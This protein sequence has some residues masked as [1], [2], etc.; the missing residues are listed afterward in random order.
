MK[1]A[2][3]GWAQQT[4]LVAKVYGIPVRVDYRWFAVF[5]LSVWLMA[6]NLHNGAGVMRAVPWA[7]AWLLGIL[8]TCG[9]FLCI[10]GHELAHAIIARME[11]IET[12][13]IVLHPFGGL[14]RLA[15]LPETPKAEFRIALA[16]P[17]AS[18]MFAALLLGA[19]LIA[20]A[21]DYQ[22][23]AGCFFLLFFGNL[24]L[25]I[26]NLFP[27][28]PLDGGRVLR[29]Y[30]WARTGDMNEAT[31]KASRLGQFIA[32][33]IIAFGA[34][35][36]I[37][38]FFNRSGD[39][40][41]GLWSILIGFFLRGAAA[42]VN[43]EETAAATSSVAQ[44]MGAPLTLSPETLVSEFVDHTLEKY[45]YAVF[46]VGQAG[47]LHGM[48]LLEDVKKL[49]RERWRTVRLRE[50]MRPVAPEMFVQTSTKLAQARELMQKNGAQAVVVLDDKGLIVGFLRA[51][52]V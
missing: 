46:P 14:A 43:R 28:Y 7:T 36:L 42:G 15:R 9:F 4:L 13:E 12:E 48:L 41:T 18:F 5:L 45:R 52:Q 49:P 16:G 33:A 34:F 10:F 50:V 24:L 2:K 51:A 30:L 38:F 26:F 23:A 35:L 32:W 6:S 1:V 29:A 21:G 37:R 17:A 39:L 22:L 3:G 20:G 40:F 27:G 19:T 31:R 44:K 11:G 8:T 25:A 47:R